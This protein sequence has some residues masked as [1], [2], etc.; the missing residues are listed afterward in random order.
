VT[1]QADTRQQL[2]L[3]DCRIETTP[4]WADWGGREAAI[5]TL[6]D[7]LD[8]W[9][10][11]WQLAARPAPRWS[12]EPRE[13]WPGD[14]VAR[15]RRDE[16]DPGVFVRLPAPREATPE[17]VAAAL[18][19]AAVA[20][21]RAWLTPALVGRPDAEP[22][23]LALIHEGATRGFAPERFRAAAPAAAVS[24]EE[25]C[26]QLV[27]AEV[28]RLRVQLGDPARLEG[29][30]GD[31]LRWT[32][33]VEMM[34]NGL[35]FESGQLLPWV[36]VEADTRLAPDEVRIWVND[37]PL[38]LRHALLPGQVMVNETPERLQLL[39]L[40]GRAIVNPA[41]GNDCSLL[42]DAAA[43]VARIQAA[44]LTAWG[45]AGYLVLTLAAV[46]RRHAAAFWTAT[47]TDAA[48]DDLGTA[49]PA[50]EQTWR[51]RFPLP[52]LTA[53]MR[54]L[55]DEQVGVR[56]LRAILEAM[57]AVQTVV[58]ADADKIV[59]APPQGRIMV[60]DSRRDKLPPG[61]AELSA[62]DWVGQVRIALAR[63]L[64]HQHTRGEATL[65]VYLLAPELETRVRDDAA[66]LAGVDGH[67]R[68][69]TA[70]DAEIEARVRRHPP[71]ILTT[72]AVRP[73]LRRL[74]RADLPELVVL[75]YE[76]LSP[77]MNIQP[78]GRVAWVE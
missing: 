36:E 53:V 1:S 11:E 25:R 65:L 63:Q 75:D 45:P 69:F 71:V 55:L 43:A 58:P 68:L 10:A 54:R 24:V 39:G 70:I 51:E 2:P 7:A 22:A 56:N 15:L 28:L 12:A 6:R 3:L 32:A 76:E 13:R 48:L 19:E 5:A 18:A 61:P 17:A 16:N 37:L 77:E 42:D 31:D 60:C 40:V 21:R 44:G 67:L 14:N 20:H 26:D 59:F 52:L 4:A 46:A 47:A 78:L 62:D 30:P 49:F 9:W 34:N 29:A 38:P 35:F 41:N 64:S 57:L 8:A 23:D 72:K 74:L 50:L 33:A 66:T 27:D 73:A